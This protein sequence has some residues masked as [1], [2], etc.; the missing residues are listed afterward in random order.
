MLIIRN[1]HVGRQRLYNECAITVA[2]SM[3]G[4]IRQRELMRVAQENRAILARI[5]AA[6]PHYNHKKWVRT[7][8]TLGWEVVCVCPY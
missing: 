7:R 6:R 8:L 2:C 5:E 4:P 3:N 1:Y